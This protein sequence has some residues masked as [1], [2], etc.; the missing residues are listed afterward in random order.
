M[1]NAAATK[2]VLA[3]LGDG[4]AN[5]GEFRTRAE[6]LRVHLLHDQALAGRVDVVIVQPPRVSREGIPEQPDDATAYGSFMRR[7]QA[8]KL[9]GSASVGLVLEGMRS[10]GAAWAVLLW[11]TAEPFGRK[12]PSFPF[13]MVAAARSDAGLVALHELGH[14]IGGLADEYVDG[15]LALPAHEFDEPNLSIHA[16]GRKW[17]NLL[18]VPS[19]NGQAVGSHRGASAYPAAFRP[20][21][22]TKM[23]DHREPWSPVDL[24]AMWRAIAGA[25]PRRLAG[26]VNGDGRVDFEDL[27]I[28]LSEFGEKGVLAGDVDHDGDVDAADLNATLSDFGEGA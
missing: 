26:D 12:H 6:M 7:N 8:G 2:P 20:C 22:S 25:T 13:C 1:T 17:A 11:N 18:G 27:N 3:I 5:P 4:F 28:V 16:D 15:R 9:G 23:R 10:V 21:A 14:V 24:L 19:A